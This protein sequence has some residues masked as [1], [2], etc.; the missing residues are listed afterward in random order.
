MAK[1]RTDGL[2]CLECLGEAKVDGDPFPDGLVRPAVTLVPH[3]VP[4]PGGQAVVVAV[5]CCYE[6]LVV[7]QPSPLAVAS[8]GW[9][10]D[11]A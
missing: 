8:A 7:Q 6:H 11:A 3:L 4:V 2:F 5:P 9:G 1:K 10:P